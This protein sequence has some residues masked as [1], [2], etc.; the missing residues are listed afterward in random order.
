MKVTKTDWLVPAGLI[1]LSLVPA[2]AAISRLTQLVGGAEVT[3]E[4]ARFMASPLPAALHVTGAVVY[5]MLGAFQFSRAIRKRWREWHRAAGKL[6]VP[7]ALIVAGSGLWM[8]VTY[9]MPATDNQFVYA[10]RLVFGTAMILSVIFAVNALRVRDFTTHGEWMIRAYAIGLGAGTQVF[11]HLPWFIFVGGMP[12]GT[13]RAVMMGAGW[14]INVVIAEWII[15]RKAVR[16]SG[17]VA[18]AA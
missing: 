18:A 3:P 9:T 14:V 5:G 13:P 7:C 6:L 1:V 10:E 16:R 17:I 11:T 2:L 15:R 8:T 12:G 4:N